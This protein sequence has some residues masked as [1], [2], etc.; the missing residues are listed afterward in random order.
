MLPDD[1]RRCDFVASESANDRDSDSGSSTETSDTETSDTA[2]VHN[3]VPLIRAAIA[4]TP[5][6]DLARRERFDQAR[7]LNMRTGYCIESV[8]M[9]LAAGA[10]N[11]VPI[12][13]MWDHMLRTC[14]DRYSDVFWNFFLKLHRFPQV[15]VDA[16]LTQARLLPFFP[17]ELCRQFPNSRR[18]MMRHL[19][20]IPAFWQIVQH[21][22][23][24]DVSHFDLPSGTRFLDFEFIDP[25]WG[26]LVAARRHHPADLH[27]I[28]LAQNRTR[29]PVYGG[30]VQYGEFLRHAFTTRAEGSYTMLVTLHWD[31]THGRGLE[32]T[33]F[34]VG[35]GNIN[36]CAESKETC[37][38]YCPSTPDQ[39]QPEFRKSSKC[40]K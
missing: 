4:P 24:I 15:A 19:G 33:P 22:H 31:G 20:C 21:T 2:S 9:E 34:A 8:D 39:R 5:L 1:P 37:I 16:A 38:A 18:S 28:P 3:G 36:N 35:V 10:R 30:G 26:W 23:R 12:Q 32:V 11:F 40:T 25:I 14:A 13:D 6:H 29:A 17:N 27:W 7:A